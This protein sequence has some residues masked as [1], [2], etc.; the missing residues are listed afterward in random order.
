MRIAGG[1]AGDIKMNGK[2]TKDLSCRCCVLFNFKWSK[3]IKEAQK[4]IS[5]FKKENR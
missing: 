1:A 2:K 4:E 3:R 5:D